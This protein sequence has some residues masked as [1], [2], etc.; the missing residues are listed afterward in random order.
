MKGIRCTDLAAA[1]TKRKAPHGLLAGRAVHKQDLDAELALCAQTPGFKILRI[2]VLAADPD[3]ETFVQPGTACPEYFILCD[4]TQTELLFGP[5]Y[6]R[7]LEAAR[8]KPSNPVSIAQLYH[9]SA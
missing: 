8:Y 5:N 3:Q 9:P 2:L 7:Y 1:Y 6:L 4:E